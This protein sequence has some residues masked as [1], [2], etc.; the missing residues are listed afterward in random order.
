LKEVR[1]KLKPGLYVIGLDFHIGF[2]LIEKEEIYFIH[3]SYRSPVAVVK[4][5]ASASL[6]LND[7]H[8]F[9]LTC[10]S[11]NKKILKKWMNGEQLIVQ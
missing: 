4:E 7:S 5:K 10:L 3:S 8:S 11:T 2:L 6:A 1:L 9:M